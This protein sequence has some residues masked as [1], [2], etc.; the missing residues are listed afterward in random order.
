[1]VGP[2]FSNTII[3]YALPCLREVKQL[4]V[5][6]NTDPSGSAI[7]FGETPHTV[8][9]RNI[10]WAPASFPSLD[11]LYLIDNTI[12][13]SD[14]RTPD[15]ASEVFYG[16]GCRFVEVLTDDPAWCNAGPIRHAVRSY[17]ADYLTAQDAQKWRDGIR[18][19][20]RVS[21]GSKVLPFAIWSRSVR[22]DPDFW[23]NATHRQEATFK[24]LACLVN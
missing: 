17:Q 9:D 14:G 19:W 10:L 15:P 7:A 20:R 21:H 6:W 5:S 23:A 22:K 2:A 13:L 12:C 18:M 16:N 24:I 4:A 3:G 1:M 8:R 11:G